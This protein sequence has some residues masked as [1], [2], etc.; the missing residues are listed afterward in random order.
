MRRACAGAVWQSLPPADWACAGGRAVARR[1]GDG[2]T[3]SYN[4][5]GCVED[6]A[7]RGDSAGGMVVSAVTALRETCRAVASP[8]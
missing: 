6:M 3:D 7:D 8:A 5:R 2:M 1:C 4:A